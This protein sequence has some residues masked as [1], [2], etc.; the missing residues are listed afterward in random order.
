VGL[1]NTLKEKSAS[2]GKSSVQDGGYEVEACILTDVGCHRDHNEDSIVYVRPAESSQLANKGLLA[3]VADGMGGHQAGEV[4]SQMAVDVIRRN[5][6][7][8]EGEDSL[9][10]LEEAFIEANQRICEASSQELSLRGMGTTATAL[11]LRR[12]NVGDSRLYRLYGGELTLLTEDHTLVMEM[13]KSGLLTAEEARLHPHKNII[14]RALGTHPR[15]AI[16]K[17]AD[18]AP[19]QVGDRFILCSDGLYDLV[20]D[21]E[22]RDIVASKAPQEACEQLVSLAKERGGH[23]N[24]SIG[25]LSIY[26]EAEVDKAVPETHETRVQVK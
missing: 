1:D 23:D 7:D 5:Y 9:E 4:A 15:V 14:T 21:A 22:I 11:V 8:C 10:A 3:I 24:I 2:N 19:V 25:I 18:L 17:S 12:G 20:S 16:A 13:V 6:Y 26:G